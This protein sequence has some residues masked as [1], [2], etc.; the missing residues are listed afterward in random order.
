MD[1]VN[2][3]NKAIEL[4]KDHLDRLQAKIDELRKEIEEQ[5]KESKVIK[6]KWLVTVSKPRGYSANPRGYRH[7]YVR[8]NITHPGQTNTNLCQV[9][10]N[11]YDATCLSLKIAQLPEMVRIIQSI[12]TKGIAEDS[13]PE[14]IEKA[15]EI[16]DNCNPL[17]H[18]VKYNK[19]LHRNVIV[20]TTSNEPARVC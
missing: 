10:G 11:E 5:E 1:K 9:Y 6:E 20:K 8:S 12:A 13:I 19:D 14:L 3:T 16:V 17:K 18:E 15:K 7:F 4:K 2:T